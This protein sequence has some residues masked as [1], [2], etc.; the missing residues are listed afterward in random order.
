MDYA[1]GDLAY[2]V[3]FL[4]ETCMWNVDRVMATFREAAGVEWMVSCVIQTAA[5]ATDAVGNAA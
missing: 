1:S 3:K 4:I 5:T 2:A